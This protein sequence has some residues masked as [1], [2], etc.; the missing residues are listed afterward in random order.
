MSNQ[1]AIVVVTYNRPNSLERLLKSIA[2]AS[3]SGSDITLVISIDKS[4]DDITNSVAENFVWNFGKKKIIRREQHLGLK[5][6]ILNC[7]DLSNEYG[8]VIILEDDLLVSPYYYKYAC[9]AESYYSDDKN[10]AGISLYNY[11]VAESCFYPFQ[12]IDDDSDVYFMQVASSW[13]QLFTKQQWNNFRKW[14]SNNPNLIHDPS[15]PEYLHQ[16]GKHSW[17]KHYIHYLIDTGKYFVFPRLA[18]STNFE[19]Q[20]TNSSSKSIFQVPVQ[21]HEKKYI[22]QNWDKSLALYDAWFE[23]KPELFKNLKDY[24][25]E[26]DLY[27]SK[28]LNNTSCNFV[29]TSKQGVDPI[30]GFSNELF[31][32]ANNVIIDLK[33]PEISLFCKPQPNLLPAQL[34]QKTLLSKNESDGFYNFSIV[35]LINDIKPELFD[36]TIKNISAIEYSFLELLIVCAESQKEVINEKLSLLRFKYKIIP[37]LNPAVTSVFNLSLIE[38]GRIFCILK[39]GETLKKDALQKVN[40]I[41]QTF[42]HINWI[43]GVSEEFRSSDR[44]EVLNAGKFR[45]IPNDILDQVQKGTL[46]Y[47]LNHH[48]FRKSDDLNILRDEK[49]VFLYHVKK[50]QLHVVLD[51]FMQTVISVQ[52]KGIDENEKNTILEG[53]AQFGQKHSFRLK[54]LNFVMKLPFFG[55]KT[56]QKWFLFVAKDYP[57]VIRVDELSGFYYLNKF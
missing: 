33:G 2:G 34:R 24:D 15:I 14:Y 11:Q 53:L 6:H 28:P 40:L 46:D 39:T 30:L 22:F 54:F 32:L 52:P 47:S 25:F 57:D 9:E 4:Y 1:P 41:F 35:I 29:L 45:L 21:L 36:D 26:V 49:S 31:P 3:Y 20:G 37:V 56:A 18:L 55:D 19:E 38:T 7:G 44:Y 8:S 51:V 12:P 48:F 13:G 43:R 16:W 10:I 23:P 17:K 50:Y 5:Q 42:R 27:G